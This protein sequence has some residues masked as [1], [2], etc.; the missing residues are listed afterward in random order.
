MT[1]Q[2]DMISMEPIAWLKSDFVQ[3]FGTPRQGPLAPA[4]RGEIELVRAWRGKGVFEG[5]SGFSHIW[6][7]SYFHAN[8]E[9]KIP[10]KIRPPRLE[11]AKVGLFATRSPHRPNAL[12]LSLAKIERVE[13]DRLFISGVDLIHDTPI[14][15]LKPYIAQADRPET[16]RGGWTEDLAGTNDR[17]IDFSDEVGLQLEALGPEGKR[18]RELIT[19]TLMLDPRPQAYKPRANERFAMWVADQNVIFEFKN[20]QFQV[21]SLEK[22]SRLAKAGAKAKRPPKESSNRR[23]VAKP[24]PGPSDR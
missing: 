21:L 22:R 23:K 4:S 9:S 17:R 18:L 11:G 2:K 14:L 16:F 12:G 20:G 3:K 5:L 7:L 1:S 6:I 8:G 19:Q 15:D 13:G 10:G 24:R